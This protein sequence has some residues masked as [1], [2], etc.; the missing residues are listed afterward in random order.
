MMQFD[1]HSRRHRMVCRENRDGSCTRDHSY[2]FCND[3]TP[4]Q[5]L[6]RPLRL[7][8]LSFNLLIHLRGYPR[9]LTLRMFENV[10]NEHCGA[11]GP[12]RSLSDG[13]RIKNDGGCG[14]KRGIRDGRV[15]VIVRRRRRCEEKLRDGRAVVPAKG[16]ERMTS[17]VCV[18]TSSSVLARN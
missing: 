10:M 3:E 4:K 11:L 1:N 9:F 16:S 2:R 7:P 15:F 18:N 8:R 12:S 17:T 13:K 6:A 5:L 14:V